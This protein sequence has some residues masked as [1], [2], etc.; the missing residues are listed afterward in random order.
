MIPS[1]LHERLL[2]AAGDRTYRHIGELTRTHP[3]TV[4]R[5]MQGQAPAADFL[6]SLCAALHISGDWLLTGR[7]PM[8]LDEQRSHALREATA[9]DLL[10]AMAGTIERLAE[11]ID[12][13]ET[14]VQTLEVRLR[15]ILSV[16]PGAPAL[17]LTPHQEPGHGSSNGQH[18]AGP[19]HAGPD[20]SGAHAPAFQVAANGKP[21]AGPS[22]ER[23]RRLQ[24]ALAQ[25]PHPHAD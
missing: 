6:A 19:Q 18:T 8:K 25:R 24:R 13:L 12:R 17:P 21:P 10:T 11:R 1:A 5:Y 9:G 4:R 7:G 20:S 23:V 22:P 16:E 14:Y 15:S 2:A 3:E